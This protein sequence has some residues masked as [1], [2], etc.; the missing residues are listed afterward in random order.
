MFDDEAEP[1]GSADSP[2]IS[3]ER[4]ERDGGF[5]ETDNRC[6]LEE[7]G[8]DMSEI[9]WGTRVFVKAEPD[10]LS[11]FG[12]VVNYSPEYDVYDIVDWNGVI[13]YRSAELV[14]VAHSVH[15]HDPGT[16]YDCLACESECFCDAMG[17]FNR[18]IHCDLEQ[19]AELRELYFGCGE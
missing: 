8:L 13:V 17:A 2:G 4:W 5:R 9:A 7:R 16:L 15:P 6:F 3:L 11:F 10:R 1:S 19:N 14:S 12:T 18:C